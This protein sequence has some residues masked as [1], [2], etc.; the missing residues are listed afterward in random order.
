MSGLSQEHHKFL[1]EMLENEKTP[2]PLDEFCFDEQLAFIQDKARNKVAVCSR[3]SG[4]TVACA[5]HLMH[6]AITKPGRVNL[7]I[8][9][10]RLNAKRIIWNELLSI[11]SRFNLGAV[12]NETELSLRFTNDSIIYLSGAKDRAEIDKFRGIPI[13]L[14]YIDE[15][16]SFRAHLKEL[17]DD[18]ISPALMDYAG[19]LCLIGT[20][21]PVPAGYFHDC[22]TKSEGWSKHG[23]TFWQNPHIALKSGLTHQQALE[24]ELEQRGVTSDDPSIQR[25]FF[26]R[27]VLDSDSLL[28][29]YDAKKNHFETLPPGKWN[30]LCGIDLGFTDADAIAVLAWS[31]SSPI[32]YLVE[33]IVTRKQDLTSLVAQIQATIGKY[34]CSKL[35]VD[36]G[37]LGKKMAEEMRRRFHIPLHAADKARKME[38]VTILNDSLRTGRFMAKKNGKFAQ[39]S[40]LVE[41]DRDKTTPDRIKVKDSYHS[42]IIDA[43][44]YAFKESPA[45]SYRIPAPPSP[46]WGTT[47]WAESQVTEMERMAE[48]HFM[49]QKEEEEWSW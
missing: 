18:V 13:N 40:Y 8:T 11:N 36:E 26:G 15:C 41:I 12:P 33:E 44:L 46:A 17:I 5:A 45:F 49:N 30:Y 34:D 39:D 29:H 22:S 1:T 24:H 38:N 9:L 20:P 23:W 37:G 32:T 47:Q 16:Q 25:E 28:L 7:Y 2:F 27:W 21:G 43:V 14:C 10:S 19:T 31:E 42:D 6:E 48:E 4:K 35:V 3:R